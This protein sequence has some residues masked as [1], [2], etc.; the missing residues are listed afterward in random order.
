MATTV[1]NK[2]KDPIA[3][4]FGC[5]DRIG[6]MELSGGYKTFCYWIKRPIGQLGL[7]GGLGLALFFLLKK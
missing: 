6:M 5:P 2:A 1:G 4:A 3:A 7:F